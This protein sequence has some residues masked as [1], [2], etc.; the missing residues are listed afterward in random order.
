MIFIQA[1]DGLVVMDAEHGVLTAG[2][3]FYWQEVSTPSGGSSGTAFK[4]TGQTWD[5]TLAGYIDYTFKI[6]TARNFNLFFRTHTQGREGKIWVEL[7][8]QLN[9][10]GP[11]DN[12]RLY[13]R[14]NSFTWQNGYDNAQVYLAAGTH[15][16]RVRSLTKAMTLDRLA[17]VPAGSS[18]ITAGLTTEGPAETG[19]GAAPTNEKPYTYKDWLADS[20]RDSH[21]V[22]LIELDHAGGTI[23][24]GSDAFMCDQHHAYDPWLLSS[25]SM[26][27]S[28]TSLAD[29]IGDIEAYLPLHVSDSWINNEWRGYRCRMYH[30]DKSW[31]KSDFR[32]VAAATIE[33]IKPTGSRQYR[34]EIAGDIQNYNRTYYTGADVTQT[35]QVDNAIDWICDQGG[36]SKPVYLNLDNGEIDVWTVLDVTE[37]SNMYADIK[38]IAASVGAF[39]RVNQIGELEIIK[40]DTGGEP[41][42]SLSNDDVSDG[43]VSEVEN[44]PAYKRVIVTYGNSDAQVKGETLAL[45]GHMDEEITVSSALQSSTDAT[46]LLSV[47]SV[48]YGKVQREWSVGVFHLTSILREGDYIEINHEDLQGAGVITNIK[49]SLDSTLGTIEVLI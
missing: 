7:D 41:T 13:F 8:G 42:V 48:Q 1:P 19:T 22:L 25:P 33:G 47:N 12:G 44:I 36:M 37:S 34:F 14:T 27:Y 18:V 6:S 28:L 40:P 30:G 10:V 45:T 4:P 26:E 49:P 35:L 31:K 20:S 23:Y 24:L 11:S 3:A 29:G 39:P 43:S 5:K 9:A 32:L 46:A 38:S 17:V 2:D 16:L 21:R 15:T